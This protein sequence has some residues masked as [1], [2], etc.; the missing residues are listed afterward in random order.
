MMKLWNWFPQDRFY[1]KFIKTK[2]YRSA[3]NFESASILMGFES[4]SLTLQN[5][6]FGL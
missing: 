2:Q 3:F 1:Q 5:K 4:L 6:F